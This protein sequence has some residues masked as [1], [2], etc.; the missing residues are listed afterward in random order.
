[1]AWLDTGT[2]QS[3]LEA[4]NFVATL[5]NRQGLK[6]GCVE[7]VAF[8]MGFIGLEQLDALAAGLGKSEYGR[9][10]KGVVGE[11]RERRKRRV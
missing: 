6:V 4:S 3:L 2:P 8:L 1:M 11:E 10:L 9:Y 5:E 7:E